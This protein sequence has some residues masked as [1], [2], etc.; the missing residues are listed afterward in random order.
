MIK[1]STAVSSSPKYL[2]DR[3]GLAKHTPPC[4]EIHINSTRPTAGRLEKFLGSRLRHL[5][6]LSPRSSRESCT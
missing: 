3:A 2:A 4:S 6:Q 5:L 1:F